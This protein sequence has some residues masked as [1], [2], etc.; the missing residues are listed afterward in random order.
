M[1]R[2]KTDD[3]IYTNHM[4][5]KLY[6]MKTMS[7]NVFRVTLHIDQIKKHRKIVSKGFLRL[8]IMFVFTISLLE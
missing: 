5:K 7:Q 3:K 4:I 8:I 1:K 6:D 2:A